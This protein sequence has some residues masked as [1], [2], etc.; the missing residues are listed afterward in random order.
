[1]SEVRSDL[2]T[3]FF[4]LLRAACLPA[5]PTFLSLAAIQNVVLGSLISSLP[6]DLLKSSLSCQKKYQLRDSI[7]VE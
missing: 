1:M 3:L 7:L 6:L 4:H 5:H 2:F